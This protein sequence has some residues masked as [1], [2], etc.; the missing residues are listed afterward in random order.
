MR[1]SPRLDVIPYSAVGRRSCSPDA[2]Q[3]NP[4]YDCDASPVLPADVW[5]HEASSCPPWRYSE[6]CLL[7]HT[8]PR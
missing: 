2:A 7:T 5:S 4:G 1:I 6:R 3:R 8:N